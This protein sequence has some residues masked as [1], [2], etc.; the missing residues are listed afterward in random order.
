MR[1]EQKLT[2]SL[3]KNPAHVATRAGELAR[4]QKEKGLK[5]QT[6]TGDGCESIEGM[7]MVISD[8]DITVERVDLKSMPKK[9]RDLLREKMIDFNQP[10]CIHLKSGG[11]VKRRLGVTFVINER[12]KFGEVNVKMIRMEGG[13]KL[14]ADIYLDS[15]KMLFVVANKVSLTAKTGTLGDLF[16]AGVEIDPSWEKN[17]VSMLQSVNG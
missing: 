11:K 1:L 12:I 6:L 14:D 3:D 4:R 8:S 5:F 15:A 7:V 13:A 10:N 9:H 17:S 2:R 16:A